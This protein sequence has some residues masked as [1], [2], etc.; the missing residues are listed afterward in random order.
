MGAPFPTK[1]SKTI[2]ASVSRAGS[3]DLCWRCK[4]VVAF[5]EDSHR[6]DNQE[7]ASTTKSSSLWPAGFHQRVHLHT[8]HANRDDQEPASAFGF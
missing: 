5:W 6:P 4:H 3:L 1:G 8:I 7:L 2:P